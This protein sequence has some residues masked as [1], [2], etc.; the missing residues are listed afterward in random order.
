[1]LFPMQYHAYEITDKFGHVRELVT[2]ATT[3]N[4]TFFNYSWQLGK[5]HSKI[6]I[7]FH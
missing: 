2:I 3:T 5:Q 4:N 6:T 7:R 1:M